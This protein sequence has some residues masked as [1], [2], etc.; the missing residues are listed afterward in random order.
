MRLPALL[1]LDLAKFNPCPL[2]TIRR[3]L[4]QVV[5]ILSSINLALGRE[6]KLYNKNK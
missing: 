6:K 5:Q 2:G 3:I 4:L 1:I